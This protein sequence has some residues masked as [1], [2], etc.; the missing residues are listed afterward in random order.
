ML[1][2]SMTSLLVEFKNLAASCLVIIITADY[3]IAG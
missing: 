2:C 3:F 1:P